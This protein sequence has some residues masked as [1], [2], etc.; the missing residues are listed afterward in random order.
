MKEYSWP[1]KGAAV[2]LTGS[3]VG[4]FWV[5]TDFALDYGLLGWIIFAIVF[6]PLY[7]IGEELSDRVFSIEAG[8]HISDQSFSWKRIAVGFFLVIGV[9]GT[10]SATY[11]LIKH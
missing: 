8:Q 6:I 3:V 11:W 1:A 7:A 10:A 5:F 9:L 4:L 2:F